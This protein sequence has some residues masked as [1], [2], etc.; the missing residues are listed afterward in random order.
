M[1]LDHPLRAGSSVL[2]EDTV[3]S[4]L[5]A[6][7]QH[8]GSA[9]ESGGI[10]MGYRRADHLH[11]VTATRPGPRDRRKRYSFERKDPT[12][13][14]QALT[15]W[16]RSGGR[17]DYLGEWH[18]HAEPQPSPSSIDVTEWERICRLT[19]QPM[20]FLIVGTVGNWFGVGEGRQLARANGKLHDEA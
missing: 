2:V 8:S 10:L 15:G 1:L 17:M 20:L 19:G 4:R 9:T 14:A 3:L 18:T 7:R 12:H 16:R 6:Y 11:I 13:Q 5:E